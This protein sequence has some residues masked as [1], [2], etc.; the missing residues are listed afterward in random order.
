MKQWYYHIDGQLSGPCPQEEIVEK[1]GAGEIDAEELV[2]RDGDEKWRP[3][4]E[5]EELFL[6][7]VAENQPTV[8][9]RGWLKRGL[10]LVSILA[11]A[12]S[13][14]LLREN[15]GL[16]KKV[17]V[18]TQ[19]E[20]ISE[21][22]VKRKQILTRKETI[23]KLSTKPVL[24]FSRSRS[25]LEKGIISVKTANLSGQ[26]M[27][28]EVVGSAGGLI[29]KRGYY[30]SFEWPVSKDL[31]S[32]NLFKKGVPQGDVEVTLRI[33]K[34]TDR[35]QVWLGPKKRA[36]QRL[37]AYLKKNAR[38]IVL[39]REQLRKSLHDMLKTLDEMK[40]KKDLL[41]LKKLIRS[42][43]YSKIRK[44]TNLF[45]RAQWKRMLDLG[46]QCQK[47]CAQGRYKLNFKVVN[48]TKQSVQRI[49]NA[50]AKQS[51][52]KSSTSIAL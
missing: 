36:R 48:S 37:R 18:I 52:W 23:K 31:T 50:M 29:G 25:S 17:E 34:H 45:Y 47:N 42:T 35:V 40:K 16:R 41:I 8:L 2:F 4:R 14:V 20:N 19:A 6:P 5:F 15:E 30:R 27:T 33:K 7:R 39:E 43:S 32:V 28:I 49:L 22:P 3:A 51:V 26:R 9:K 11:V 46:L 1:I 44:A 10:V 13:A 21:L 38:L 12:I 24:Q